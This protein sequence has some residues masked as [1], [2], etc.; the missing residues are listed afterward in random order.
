M[1][2]IQKIINDLNVNGDHFDELLKS[3][4][5]NHKKTDWKGFPNGKREVDADT[6][7]NNI[8]K[9][10]ANNNLTKDDLVRRDAVLKNVFAKIPL[11]DEWKAALRWKQEFPLRSDAHELGVEAYMNVLKDVHDIKNESEL[12]NI[13]LCVK[14]KKI[15]GVDLRAKKI[16]L[17]IIL[18]A[19]VACMRLGYTTMT[20]ETTTRYDPTDTDQEKLERQQS[21]GTVAS[22]IVSVSFGVLNFLVD[23]FGE[24][25]A[26]TSTALVGMVFG[27]TLG[28]LMDNTIGSDEGYRIVCEEGKMKAWKYAL[29]LMTSGTYLR[30]T[31]TV[32]L[33]VFI[34]LIIFKPLYA[35]LVNLPYLRCNNR[36]LANGIASTVI[37]ITTFQAYANVTRFA[38]AYPSTNTQTTSTWI[39][40]GTMQVIVSLASVTFLISNTRLNPGENGINHPRVKLIIVIASLMLIWG[41]AK[42]DKMQPKADIEVVPNNISMVSSVIQ[43]QPGDEVQGSE[44]QDLKTGQYLSGMYVIDRSMRTNKTTKFT[45]RAVRKVPEFKYKKNNNESVTDVLNK[46]RRGSIALLLIGLCTFGPTILGTSTKDNSSK[47]AIFAGFMVLTFILATPG[48]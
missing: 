17:A 40:G 19:V 23:Y 20:D 7:V 47:M 6:F 14:N 42:M 24:V 29:G 2:E 25:N 37:G 9:L 43:R 36:A 41:L 46:S 5:D 31:L 26:A 18:F 33:D 8:K 1:N 30:Y 27:G 16:I 13:P 4:Y 34:S 38:W 10:I 21:R 22:I 11:K 28:F 12:Y 48:M 15:E 39:K 3:V 32:L 44:I 35:W 45:Y